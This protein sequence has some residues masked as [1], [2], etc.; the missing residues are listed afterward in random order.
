MTNRDVQ[1]ANSGIPDALHK[2]KQCESI[3]C[4]SLARVFTTTEQVAFE[5][6]RFNPAIHRSKDYCRFH[7]SSQLMKEPDL[8]LVCYP[9]RWVSCGV[10]W[11]PVVAHFS[12]LLRVKDEPQTLDTRHTNRGN[13]VWLFR[14]LKCVWRQQLSRHAYIGHRGTA[15]CSVR[16]SHKKSLSP[17]WQFPLI[18]Q[19]SVITEL[20][21][22]EQARRN[23]KKTAWRHV[24]LDYGLRNIRSRS[25]C[26]TWH[27]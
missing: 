25:S 14:L 11:S 20:Q 19:C 24:H 26:L 23:W 22:S 10:G 1:Y 8:S 15:I 3:W 12:R 5:R 16:K 2:V 9:G 7:L 6:F 17:C 13:T 27:F 4:N 21:W 18:N